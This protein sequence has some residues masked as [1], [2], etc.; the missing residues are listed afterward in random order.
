MACD[1]G[2][3]EVSRIAWTLSP[4]NVRAMCMLTMA[5]RPRRS[6]PPL[7]TWWPF[8]ANGQGERRLVESLSPTHMP[9]LKFLQGIKGYLA[10]QGLRC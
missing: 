4:S 1:L 8:P 6:L 5:L 9:V 3:G 10:I 7:R 2:F